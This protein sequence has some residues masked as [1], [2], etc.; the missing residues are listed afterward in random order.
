MLNKINLYVFI[1]IIKSCTLIFFI[2]LSISWLL[3]ITRLFTL[4][5]LIQI[6]IFNIIYLSFFLIPNLLTIILPFII[7]FGILLCFIKFNK[8]R[9][10]IAIYSLGLQLKP[11]RYSL[12]F[13]SLIICIFYSLLNFYISPLVYEKY[14][15]KEYELR[16]TINFD[17][18]LIT[19]FIKLNDNTTIDFKKNQD[20]NYEDILI[21]FSDSSENLIFA[22]NGFIKNNNKE[23]I[24]QLNE[25]FKITINENEIEN[26]EFENYVFKVE[27]KNNIEFNNY[28]RNTLTLYDD[29]N[30]GNYLNIGFRIIDILF[31]III[32][33]FFYRYNIKN[34]NLEIKHNVIFISTSTFILIINQLLKNSE[35][36]LIFYMSITITLI[37]LIIMLTY[38][39]RKNNV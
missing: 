8:D 28:D 1:Q 24:F 34:N 5:N 13:F 31:I 19:N 32:I 37:I 7:I 18:M 22:K 17:K 12:L 3:Q 25:G 4:T 29:L 14:K 39:L 6:D 26:L 11:L 10:I 35:I 23:Y 27:N 15:I 30:S 21:S 38:I 2:F 33:N 16:N 9:E 20:S 36:S